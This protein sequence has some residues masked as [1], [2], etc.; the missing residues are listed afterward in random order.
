MHL[1]PLFTETDHAVL[2]DFIKAHPL[3]TLIS[4]KDG[5]P[6]ADLLP[7]YVVQKDDTLIAHFAKANPLAEYVNGTDVMILFYGEEG[8]TRPT[9]IHPNT[10]TTAMCQRG[11]MKWCRCVG[12]LAC[13]MMSRDSCVRLAP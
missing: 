3:G 1:P 12:V 5:T 6:Q 2:T 11:I 9:G 13:L 4:I 7:F 10:S 8:Y